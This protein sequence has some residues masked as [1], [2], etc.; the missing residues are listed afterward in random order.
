M[1]NLPSLEMGHMATGHC[2]A[3]IDEDVRLA[4]DYE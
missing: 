2:S 3:M 1:K 4:Y